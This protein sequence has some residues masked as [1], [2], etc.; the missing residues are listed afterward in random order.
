MG[1]IIKFKIKLTIY[2]KNIKRLKSCKKI[3]S[4]ITEI[5]N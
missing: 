1:Y 3:E 2:I 4:K 5:K